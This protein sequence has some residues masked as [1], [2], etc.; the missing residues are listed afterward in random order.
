[1][2]RGRDRGFLKIGGQGG[3]RGLPHNLKG[4]Y[5]SENTVHVQCMHSPA[6]ERGSILCVFVGPG[7]AKNEHR[8][9]CWIIDILISK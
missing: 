1:M 7:A 8:Q 6:R 3:G 4:A 9:E 2:Y 5:L